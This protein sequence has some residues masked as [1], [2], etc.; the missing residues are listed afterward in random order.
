MSIQF[1]RHYRVKG[2][3]K[4]IIRSETLLNKSIFINIIGIVSRLL[5]SLQFRIAKFTIH[6]NSFR[7]NGL[8]LATVY[9]SELCTNVQLFVIITYTV[10]LKNYVSAIYENYLIAL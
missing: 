9:G 10:N 6:W 1:R 4:L 8:F 3:F 5:D 2:F 7:K